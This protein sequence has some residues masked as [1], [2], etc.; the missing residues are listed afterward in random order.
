MASSTAPYSAGARY[1][2]SIGKR[3]MESEAESAFDSPYMVECFPRR[4]NWSRT[5]RPLLDNHEL[6]FQNPNHIAEKVRGGS[7]DCLQ[8]GISHADVA[9]GHA[10]EKGLVGDTES[11]AGVIG[12]PCTTR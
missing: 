9:S 5:I 11:R 2:V 7:D 1:R 10:H 3:M 8:G 6:V 12:A 4:A